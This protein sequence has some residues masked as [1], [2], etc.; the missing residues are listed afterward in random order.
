MAAVDCF[1]EQLRDQEPNPS[2]TDGI[3]EWN[4]VLSL[5]KLRHDVTQFQRLA[6]LPVPNAQLFAS[7][8]RCLSSV[9][10]AVEMRA[11]FARIFALDGFR[12]H[13]YWRSFVAGAWFPGLEG[14]PFFLSPH[15]EFGEGGASEDPSMLTVNTSVAL[16][17]DYYRYLHHR[18]LQTGLERKAHAVTA[19]RSIF[20]LLL[21]LRL[22]PSFD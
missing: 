3:S 18:H 7:G 14:I 13:P 12:S 9:L 19:T 16:C 5:G 8:A 15:P 17:A 6:T 20:G 4:V 1:A 2:F 21:P 10:Q 22:S 11:S